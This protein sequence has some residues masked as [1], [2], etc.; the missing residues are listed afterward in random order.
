MPKPS[1]E[2]ELSILTLSP[3]DQKRGNPF[4]AVE[5]TSEKGLP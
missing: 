1:E 5:F 4:S 3:T 2:G